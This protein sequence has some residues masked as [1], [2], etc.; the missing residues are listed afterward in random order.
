VTDLDESLLD[1]YIVAIREKLHTS[2]SGRLDS[3]AP[4]QRATILAYQ[5]ALDMSNGGF[6]T[7]F[8]N[9]TGNDWRETLLAVQIVGATQLAILLESSLTVFPDSSPSE[10]QLTRCHQ[11]AIAGN[12]AAELLWGLT[13]KYYELQAA[14][15]EHCLYQRLTAYV[16]AQDRP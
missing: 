13:G 6:A 1:A 14:S 10:D 3:L 5:L 4:P 2:G 9:P 15:A 16:L 7:F 11:L 8:T 12:P